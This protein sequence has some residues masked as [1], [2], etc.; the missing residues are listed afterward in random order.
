MITVLKSRVRAGYGI[1]CSVTA[2][3]QNPVVEA[4]LQMTIQY[5]K[6]ALK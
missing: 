1:R 6:D 5:S 4:K 2:V 3:P